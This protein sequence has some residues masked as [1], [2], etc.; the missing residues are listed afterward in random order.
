MQHLR[1]ASTVWWGA[2][3]IVAPLLGA[4]A[5]AAPAPQL[6]PGLWQ[7][8][9][10]RAVNGQVAPGG[11]AAMQQMR[12]EVRAR[13]EAAMKSR[14]VAL[15]D[16]SG[17]VRFCLTREA[18]ERGQFQSQPDNGRCTT[19]F[20]EQ[21][22]TRWKWHS[23]CVVPRISGNYVSDGVAIFHSAESYSVDIT[24]TSQALGQNRL[25]STH[26][27]AKWLQPDCGSLKPLQPRAAPGTAGR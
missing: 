27:T 1:A 18:M 4:G 19:T 21:S 20:G 5:L 12:P 17:G 9:T 26:L 7:F 25:S 8:T 3:V 6:K 2:S 15:P 24:T 10:D 13:V 11:A 22:T 14:G 16:S 23:T